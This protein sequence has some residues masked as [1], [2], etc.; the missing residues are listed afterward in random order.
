MFQ[1]MGYS[2][3]ALQGFDLI[4]AVAG[5]VKDPRR[6]LPLSMFLSLRPYRR[7]LILGGGS[8]RYTM[9]KYCTAI[10]PHFR[11]ASPIQA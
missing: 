4:A 10:I 3:I 7:D 1:A 11:H 6:V 8:S 9:P 5:E 2:F